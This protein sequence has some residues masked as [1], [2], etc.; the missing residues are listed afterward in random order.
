MKLLLFFFSISL[1]AAC[2][3]DPSD[4]RSNKYLSEKNNKTLEEIIDEE[5]NDSID[6]YP[7]HDTCL[8]YTSDAADE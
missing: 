7:I 1:L 4:D 6:F 3:T 8:L 5:I 2:A